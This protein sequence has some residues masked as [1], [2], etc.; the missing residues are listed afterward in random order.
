MTNEHLSPSITSIDDATRFDVG[1]CAYAAHENS[2]EATDAVRKA[3][4]DP[5]DVDT[6]GEKLIG[7]DLSRRG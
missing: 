2:T 3:G 7:F 5:L 4:P 1:T 6:W